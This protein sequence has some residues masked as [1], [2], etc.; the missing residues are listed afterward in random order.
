MGLFLGWST[1]IGGNFYTLWLPFGAVSV[2]FAVFFR[3]VD[4]QLAGCCCL[5]F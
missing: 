4:R 1:M 5:L 3:L 2:C